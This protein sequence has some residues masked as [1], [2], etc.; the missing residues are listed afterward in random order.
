M[1][2]YFELRKIDSNIDR[3]EE[4]LTSNSREQRI[5]VYQLWLDGYFDRTEYARTYNAHKVSPYHRTRNIMDYY[6]EI[7]YKKEDP[8]VRQILLMYLINIIQT[9]H[10]VLAADLQRTEL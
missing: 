4:V 3:I 9:V 1:H 2:Y 7:I 10:P 5:F 8:Q 6:R